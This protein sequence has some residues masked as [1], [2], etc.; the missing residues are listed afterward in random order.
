[1]IIDACPF[2]NEVDLL[3]LR[4]RT[5]DALVERFIVVQAH[6][7]HSGDPKPIYFDPTEPR[8]APW[9]SRVVN[10]VLPAMPVVESRWDRERAPRHA[11]AG[12][13]ADCAPT[14]I[15]LISD[16]DEIPDPKLVQRLA[17][18][19]SRDIW[20]GFRLA[21]YYYYLN[22]RTPRDFD[23]GA[24]ARV[25]TVREQGAQSIRD[26]YKVPPI[27]PVN[28]GW[29]F[30]WMGGADA[31]LT[32]YAAFAHGELGFE[33]EN[34]TRREWI[35]RCLRERRSFFLSSQGHF[36][37]GRFVQVPLTELPEPVQ[38]DPARWAHM[39][40]PDEVAHG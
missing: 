35:E 11:L 36:R 1:M 16:L 14:D 20:V 39:L 21:C 37:G 32:K 30:S 19:L 18:L 5:L 22:L 29:H 9:A 27:G 3:E 24:M 7:T 31:I 4:F 38:Q 13:I 2:F 33:H 17:G 23:G 26:R 25:S 15:M 40:L 8:W 28:G 12:A 10:I 34:M 6:D